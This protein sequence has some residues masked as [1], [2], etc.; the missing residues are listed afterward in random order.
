MFSGNNQDSEKLVYEPHVNLVVIYESR[1][2]HYAPASCFRPGNGS[3][4]GM[5]YFYCVYGRNVLCTWLQVDLQW[6]EESSLTNSLSYKLGLHCPM[7]AN[8]NQLTDTVFSFIAGYLQWAKDYENDPKVTET[9]P[10]IPDIALDLC[11]YKRLI[12]FNDGQIA[13]LKRTLLDF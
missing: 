13:G 9:N 8:Q 2:S 6:N 11:S 10:L 4:T 5:Q 1:T 7:D 12:G 3:S